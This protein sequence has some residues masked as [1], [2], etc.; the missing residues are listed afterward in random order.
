MA[1]WTEFQIQINGPS[2]DQQQIESLFKRHAQHTE[3]EQRPWC[4]DF[5]TMIGQHWFLPLDPWCQRE[6]NMLVIRGEMKW[7]PPLAIVGKFAELF[8]SSTFDVISTTEYEW[9]EHWRSSGGRE[10]EQIED[11]VFDWRK[12]EV[13]R[14]F[15]RYGEESEFSFLLKKTPEGS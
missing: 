9:Y 7:M 14:H 3:G 11:L 4:F 15:L 8:P 1:N 5:E 10:P 6:G 12:E 2:A 13:Q